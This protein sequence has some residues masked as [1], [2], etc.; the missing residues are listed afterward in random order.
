MA[1]EAVRI[2]GCLRSECV[3]RRTEKKRRWWRLIVERGEING[4]R[5]PGAA[6][7]GVKL[8]KRTV[9]AREATSYRQISCVSHAVARLNFNRQR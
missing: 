7:A 8:R 5:P 3:T 2:L 4:R 1:E 9:D 6:P